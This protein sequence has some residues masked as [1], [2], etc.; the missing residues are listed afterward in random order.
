MA[1]ENK[2]RNSTPIILIVLLVLAAAGVLVARY[3]LRDTVEVRVASTTYQDLNASVSTNGKVEPVQGFEAHAPAAALVKDIYVSE[4]DHVD[5]GTLLV[6]LDDSEAAARLA[7]AHSN[8][9]GAQSAQKNLEH[10]GTQEETLAL[11][12][13][14][15]RA[16]TELDQAQTN[17]ATVQRLQQHGSASVAEVAAASQRVQIA[18]T[19]LQV[20]E[21]RKTSRYGT[22]DHERTAAQVAEARAAINAAAGTVNGAN[23]RAPFSGTVYSVP[24][25][26]YDFVPAGELLLNLADLNRIQVRAYFDE[27]EIGKLAVGQA[28]KIVWDAK[29][30]F[31]WHG[32]IEHAPS[33]VITYGT[34]N[35]GECVITV[36]DARGDLLPNT[37][38]TVTV[39]TLQK[40]H[41][42][43]V[44]REALRTSGADN[45][46][47]RVVNKHLVRTP[48]QVG[49]LN[50]TNIEII[51]GLKEKDVVALNA[52]AG[53]DLS[54]GLEV[55][56]VQ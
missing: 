11:N 36:D 14:I 21:Q 20:L 3:L 33:T 26:E 18:Q 28:V 10:G 30:G 56:T 52:T 54:N 8:L 5:K 35:V 15:A 23:V 25:Q 16:H 7:A 45:Y 4:G 44:P 9:V 6:R 27:P 46:V 34:R 38:V 12:A 24:V 22:V 37:N 48:V 55:K 29:P 51:S 42:L 17:L 31:A 39:T 2:S 40:F 50:L 53:L 49:A 1:K 41:V 32:H 13:D 47:Y 43:T 19:N